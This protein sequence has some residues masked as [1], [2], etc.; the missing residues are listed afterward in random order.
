MYVYIYIY[1]F[2]Y[3]F[4]ERER[5]ISRQPASRLG[6]QQQ[7]R[8]RSGMHEMQ[9]YSVDQSIMITLSTI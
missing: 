9:M 6:R 5:E 8:H 3:S 4:I 1:I 2:I 7:F